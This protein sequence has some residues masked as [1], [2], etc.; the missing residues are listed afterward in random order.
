MTDLTDRLAEEPVSHRGAVLAG[1]EEPPAADLVGGLARRQ[2][3]TADVDECPRAKRSA[4][5][6][7]L[8]PIESRRVRVNCTAQW[9]SLMPTVVSMT[10]RSSLLPFDDRTRRSSIIGAATR[11][12]LREVRWRGAG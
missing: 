9:R 7:Q 12:D 1:D 2:V 5:E 10:G 8:K 11:I 4:A 6:Q 3:G